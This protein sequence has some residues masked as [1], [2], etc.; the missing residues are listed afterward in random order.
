[1][2][3]S[4]SPESC[5]KLSRNRN[6]NVILIAFFA[7]VAF[8]LD[9]WSKGIITKNFLPGE[10]KLAI[11]GLLRW[12]YEQNTHG[13]FGLFGSNAF[14]LVGMALVVLVIF[15]FAFRDAAHHSLLAR[16]GFGLIVGG[17]I[18]NIVDRVEHGSVVDFIDFYHIWP[19]IFNVADSCI[20][21]GVALLL[22]A[23][24]ATHRR[25]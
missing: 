10:S 7:F 2:P 18:G 22:I 17:A 14:M 24:L 5:I 13:A 11:N 9:Q 8:I 16:I 23:S 4:P 3:S 21:V 12:T 15:W 25:S 20:T 1:M 6:S 19:N